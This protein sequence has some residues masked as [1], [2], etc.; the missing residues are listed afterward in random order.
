MLEQ[1]RKEMGQHMN[2]AGI[3]LYSILA[4][5]AQK[6]NI[7]FTPAQLIMVMAVLCRGGLRR[8]DLRDRGR[9]PR[10]AAARS[11]AMGVG[12]V[13]VWVNSR[14]RSASRCSR[15]SCPTRSN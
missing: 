13:Y 12:G 1:L 7:A 4:D 8:P 5:K 2:V 14:P 11:V 10:S 3:P 9:R 15:N 6:A